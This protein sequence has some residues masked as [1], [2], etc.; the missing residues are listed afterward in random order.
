MAMENESRENSQTA[1]FVLLPN[2]CVVGMWGVG[3]LL[4]QMS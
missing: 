4:A 2:I 1:R 3:L